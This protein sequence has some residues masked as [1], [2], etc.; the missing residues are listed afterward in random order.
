MTTAKMAKLQEQ[1]CQPD[2]K[3]VSFSM[4]PERDTPKV[5]SEYAR[6]FNIDPERWHVVTGDRAQIVGVV[7]GLG[8]AER[9]GQTASDMIHSDRL[10]LIDRDGRVRGDYDSGNP[11]SM[12]HLADDAMALANGVR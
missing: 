1:I 12:R 11:E 3:L 6:R 5:L 2:V 8:L 7:C 10:L 4:N 9:Q